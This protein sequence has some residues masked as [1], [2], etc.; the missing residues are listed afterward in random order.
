MLDEHSA[1]LNVGG[2]VKSQGI[3]KCRSRLWSSEPWNQQWVQQSSQWEGARLHALLVDH[4]YQTRYRRESF[5]IISTAGTA[6]TCTYQVTTHFQTTWNNP[7]S[8]VTT[9][10]CQGYFNQCRVKL[11]MPWK[12]LTRAQ[13]EAHGKT[14]TN[15]K[16]QTQYK[17]WPSQGLTGRRPHG[18]LQ[19]P[20]QCTALVEPWEGENMKSK[21]MS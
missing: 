12:R 1:L 11:L 5:F 15:K 21:E 9:R 10:C 18:S 19:A 20:P 7:G 4:L 8:L 2:K 13:S 17:S 16:K 6:T 14:K 3:K